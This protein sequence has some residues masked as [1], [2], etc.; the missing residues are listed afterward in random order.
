M[1]KAGG[2][3]IRSMK[4]KLYVESKEIEFNMILLTV[5]TFLWV[6][7]ANE[8]TDHRMVSNQRRHKSVGNFFQ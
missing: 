2:N 4:I 7:A 8:Q 1:Q 5:L 6:R 3:L